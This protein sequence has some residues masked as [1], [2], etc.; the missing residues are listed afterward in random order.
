M[1]LE[2]LIRV[3]IGEQI[4]TRQLQEKANALLE[5]IL[6]NRQTG[7]DPNELLTI[8]QVAEEF[9]IGKVKVQKIFND[10]ALPVQRYTRPFKV[11]RKAIEKFFETDH[12]Y[13]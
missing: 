9:N 5:N 12:D 2:D 3:L 13:L 4:K 7:K 1:E 8:E 11:K 10:P 6:E